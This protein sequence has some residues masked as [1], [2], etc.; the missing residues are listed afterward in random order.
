VLGDIDSPA[1]LGQAVLKLLEKGKVPNKA[2]AVL[3]C[4]GAYF[5]SKIKNLKIEQ[6]NSTQ[7]FDL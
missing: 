4:Y 7:H 2:L 1:L 5:H 6:N 3:S